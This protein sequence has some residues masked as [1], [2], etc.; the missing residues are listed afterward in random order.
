[1]RIRQRHSVNHRLD[2]HECLHLPKEM[3]SLHMRISE[4][5]ESFIC[6]VCEPIIMVYFIGLET[7][8]K[9]IIS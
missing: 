8:Y 2:A 9:S 5:H 1:M 4:S 6:I 3:E 7:V